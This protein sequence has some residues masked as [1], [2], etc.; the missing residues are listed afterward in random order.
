MRAS[1]ETELLDAGFPAHVVAAWIGHSVKVQNASYAQVADHHFDL[2]VKE[3]TRE[4]S[5]QPAT[6]GAPGGAV[7]NETGGNGSEQSQINSD[8]SVVFAAAPT[9]SA[10]NLA[11]TGLE[12]VRGYPLAGF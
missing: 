6:G 4:M 5:K 3:R 2:A 8:N 1:R 9:G 10:K 12:P 11:E 7:P